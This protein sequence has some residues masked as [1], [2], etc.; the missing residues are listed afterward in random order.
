VRAWRRGP[1]AWIEHFFGPAPQQGMVA[2]RIAFGA[3]LFTSYLWRRPWIEALYGP[4][5]MG[6]S[7]LAARFPAAAFGRPIDAPFR[8]L[9]AA[10]S[11]AVVYAAWLLLLVASLCFLLGYRT[12]L[13]GALMLLLHASFV[14]RNQYAY[15]GWAWMAKAFVLYTVLAP[16]GRWVSIDAW[17]RGGV[18]ESWSGTGWPLR[19]L[20]LHVCTMYAVAGLA[21][22]EDSAWQHGE[23][24]FVAVTDRGFAR[25]DFDWHPFA[26]LLEPLSYVA[27]VAEPLAPLLLWVPVLGTAWAVLLIL[28]HF[29]L[30]LVLVGSWWQL[31]MMSAL[32]VFLPPRWLEVPLGHLD[33][34]G[35]RFVR[36]RPLPR[37][38]SEARQASHGGGKGL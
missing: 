26:A 22:F 34:I 27:F 10:D 1:G 37:P 18:A 21:R 2:C 38:G 20:K 16:S 3:L 36:R 5:G 31:M 8:W 35:R 4:S 6:G 33:A 17:R 9:A 7:E 25:F 13:A 30:D 14:A 11:L 24:V 28:L 32:L 19:L 29:L 23:M 15:F 12:R